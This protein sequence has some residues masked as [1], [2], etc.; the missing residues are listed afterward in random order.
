MPNH[1]GNLVDRPAFWSA[2]QMC[3]KSITNVR[4]ERCHMTAETSGF[5]GASSSQPAGSEASPA[6]AGGTLKRQ[7]RQLREEARDKIQRFATQ[8]K[9][10][11]ASFLKDVSNA[12]DEVTSK[13]DEQ[14]YG[15]IARYAGAAAEKLRQVGDDLPRRDL[16]DL[17]R[18]AENFARERLAVFLGALFI[19]GFGAARFLKA[20]GEASYAEGGLPTET[21]DDHP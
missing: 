17:L 5:I 21:A 19:A 6:D 12:L 13:L 4:E 20:S 14:G 11:A 2:S 7:G 15:L 3:A 10:E 16:G 18:Q 9:Q 8:R 1:K